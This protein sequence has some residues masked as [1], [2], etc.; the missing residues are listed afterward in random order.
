[1]YCTGGVRCEMASA[2]VRQHCNADSTD[3][4]V[5]QLSGGIERYLEAYPGRQVT[6]EGFGAVRAGDNEHASG[7]DNAVEEGVACGENGVSRPEGVAQ[8]EGFFRG[9]NFVFDER[10]NIFRATSSFRNALSTQCFHV[11]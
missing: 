8:E 4:E 2:L 6:V 9:K 7:E 5:L 11:L 10:Y 1:M 3:T